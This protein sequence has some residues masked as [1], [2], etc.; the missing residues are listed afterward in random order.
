[1]AVLRG[2]ASRNEIKQPTWYSSTSH[3]LTL[4]CFSPV[5]TEKC[6]RQTT[7]LAG[8]TLSSRDIEGKHQQMNWVYQAEIA[9]TNMSVLNK[10]GEN[11]GFVYWILAVHGIDVILNI[12]GG[13][14]ICKIGAP[15][16]NPS[17]ILLHISIFDIMVLTA[18]AFHL[19]S[20]LV[21]A[22][23]N[24]RSLSYST[25]ASLRFPLYMVYAILTIDRL[26]ATKYSLS[27]R[28]LLSE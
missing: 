4:Q 3:P 11:I 21:G 25:Y 9:G 15:C 1:M 10:Y 23:T 18:A 27:Y 7:R 5:Q 16:T 17:I 24:V 13:Y 8:F 22:G 20:A 14:F 26:Y 12:T 28:S 19:T 6:T 2:L